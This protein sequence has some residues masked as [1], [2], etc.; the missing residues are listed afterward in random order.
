[1]TCVDTVIFS[2]DELDLVVM[3]AGCSLDEKPGS[4]WVQDKGGLP[5]YICQIARAIKKTGKP[6]S[7]AIAIAVSRVK[8]WATGAGV[9]K[10]T[11]AKAV[12]AVAQ[13]EKMRASAKA[14]NVK[15]TR[16]GG[17]LCLAAK[18]FNVDEMAGAELS[19]QQILGLA[20]RFG[21]CGSGATD[22]LLQVGRRP[23][24]LEQIL[25]AAKRA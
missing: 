3:F 7:Q 18:S 1:M 12:K 23:T 24:A 22:I 25:A 9:D 15:A 14:D 6:T 5:D 19:D 17:V 16:S 21:P 10:D 8:K 20:A 4:N 13:W 2:R 11:Q